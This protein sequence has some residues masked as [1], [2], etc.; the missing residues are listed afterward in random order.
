ME[1]DTAMAAR[2][3]TALTGDC[4][5]TFQ[6]F[7][8]GGGGRQLNRIM[9]GA[10]SRRANALQSLNLKGAGVFVM[11]N[12]GD[13]FGRRSA[14]V[15]A[16]RALFVDLDGAPIEPV[17]SCALPPRIV[18]ESSPGKW[19]AYWPA[20][21]LPLDRF[22]EAQKALALRF[23]GDPKVCD[24]ARVMRLPGFLHNKGKPFQTRLVECRGGPV[25]WHELVQAFDLKDRLILP[26]TIPTGSRND[27][28]FRLALSAAKKG[29]PETEQLKKAHTVNAKRCDP[30]LP[31][32]EVAE[33]VAS[34]YRRPV[35]GFVAL[36]VA[37]MD[38]E[39]YRSISD[40]ARTLLLLAYRKRDPYTE[41]FTLTDTEC[42]P[43]VP[44]KKTFIRYRKELVGAGLIQP[45][46]AAEK[47]QP[48]NGKKP[49]AGFY[50]VCNR[51][52]IATH[53]TRQIGDKND[54]P[55]ALQALGSG[56]F[57]DLDSEGGPIR[58]TGRAA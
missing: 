50:R 33:I 38:G 30:P 41:L 39:P 36:P 32:A 28:L 53:D 27:T 29:V 43:W 4:T 52:Q 31:A 46:V 2:F 17:L 5:H 58:A 44:V 48:R 8:E 16:A 23:D 18:V 49:K 13:G 7:G 56:A 55:E 25:T 15:T 22:T 57:E 9:H 24:R 21:D 20:V 14:N 35:Q 45:V 54:P 26:T 37:V 40:G 6:T 10:F 11:V 34:A 51:S 12:R 47:A 42:R 19:H 3:L 1:I